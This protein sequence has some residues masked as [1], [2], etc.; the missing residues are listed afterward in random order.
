[1]FAVGATQLD[2]AGASRRVVAAS[3]RVV[4]ASKRTCARRGAAW[5]QAPNPTATWR[6]SRATMGRGPATTPRAAAAAARTRWT[7]R[8]A[9][10]LAAAAAAAALWS[11][12]LAAS[13]AAAPLSAT[14]S[15]SGRAASFSATAATT[16]TTTTTTAGADRTPDGKAQS[17]GDE[18]RP[19]PTAPPEPEEG[20][21]GMYFYIHLREV[22]CFVEEV[23]VGGTLVATYAHPEASIKAL[24]LVVTTPDGRELVDPMRAQGRF[25]FA[26]AG[27][28]EYRVCVGPARTGATAESRRPWPAASRTAKVHLRLEVLSNEESGPAASGDGGEVA[29]HS[30]VRNLE[31]MLLM[32]GHEIDLLLDDVQL[33]RERESHFR[34]QSDRINARVVH[35]SVLQ[36]L[37]LVVAGAVQSLALHRYFRAKKI[38]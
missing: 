19:R 38:A 15:G 4:A 29:R 33:A 12:S 25:A 17:G 24:S 11:A 37:V 30:H 31:Q 16:T 13:A 35:W 34:E 8:L 27:S 32:L 23:A 28:G 26:A 14:L 10:A 3:R 20:P 21:S 22:V 5:R 7:A 9:A 36:T 18:R 2:P 1:M 6:R